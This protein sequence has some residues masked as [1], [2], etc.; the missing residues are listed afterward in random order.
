MNSKRSVLHDN[1]RDDLLSSSWELHFDIWIT[2]GEHNH[3][4]LVRPTISGGWVHHAGCHIADWKLTQCISCRWVTQCQSHTC[5][6]VF[7][8]SRFFCHLG[9]SHPEPLYAKSRAPDQTDFQTYGTLPHRHT[10]LQLK[11]TPTL[12]M[13]VFE[14]ATQAWKTYCFYSRSAMSFNFC[15]W[16]RQRHS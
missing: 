8:K 5:G 16:L 4:V 12:F 10:V 6:H 3:S 11:V 7:K 15:T 2:C 1:W 14:I 9:Y 13:P